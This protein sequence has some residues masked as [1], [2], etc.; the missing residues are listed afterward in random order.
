MVKLTNVLRYT[1]EVFVSAVEISSKGKFGF[2]P[3]IISRF[4]FLPYQ[5]VVD[6]SLL[7]EVDG[8]DFVIWKYSKMNYAINGESLPYQKIDPSVGVEVYMSDEGLN[9]TVQLKS[10]SDGSFSL[11]A[12]SDGDPN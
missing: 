10:N 5:P 8:N 12:D 11:G 9:F 4:R 7:I 6:Q 1:D 3:E 2:D